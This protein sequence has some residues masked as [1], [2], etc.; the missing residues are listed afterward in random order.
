M[1]FLGLLFILIPLLACSPRPLLRFVR[2]LV[3]TPAKSPLGKSA[4]V[5][6]KSAVRF[7]SLQAIAV[8]PFRAR[9]D[10]GAA[11]D[12]PSWLRPHGDALAGLVAVPAVR[13]QVIGLADREPAK[14]SYLKP[15]LSTRWGSHLSP[16]G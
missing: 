15:Y 7:K 5:E 4:L 11:N 14:P 3:T 9:Q 8:R 10:P 2:S 6:V 16:P 1:P 12:P 13:Y